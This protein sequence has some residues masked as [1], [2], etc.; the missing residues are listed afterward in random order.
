MAVGSGRACK[1]AVNIDQE[2]Y[3]A[4]TVKRVDRAWAAGPVCRKSLGKGRCIDFAARPIPSKPP[5][6]ADLGMLCL[7]RG[8]WQGDRKAGWCGL[9]RASRV[10]CGWGP[11]SSTARRAGVRGK[12]S[13]CRSV[14][15]GVVGERYNGAVC[16]DVIAACVHRCHQIGV[17]LAVL[18]RAVDAVVDT[19]R[20]TAHKLDACAAA[21][22]SIKPAWRGKLDAIRPAAARGKAVG[23]AGVGG[24]GCNLRSGGVVGRNSY[25]CN[26]WLAAVNAAVGVVVAVDSAGNGAC[27]N[28][29]AWSWE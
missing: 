26:A 10:W 4:S 17:C 5:C 13:P 9:G 11:A 3:T 18:G 12:N 2:R 20:R 16:A 27:C 6:G 21:R 29:R 1:Y 25:A 15:A 7:D 24:G 19:S 28:R 23:S 22:A 8:V 14:G